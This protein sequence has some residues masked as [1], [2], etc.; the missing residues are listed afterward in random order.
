L[1]SEA[2]DP[3]DFNR[4]LTFLKRLGFVREADLLGHR[5][6]QRV[7]PIF[8]TSHNRMVTRYCAWVTSEE[9]SEALAHIFTR[10]SA[11][12][13]RQLGE[14]KNGRSDAYL[15][16][17]ANWITERYRVVPRIESGRLCFQLGAGLPEERRILLEVIDSKDEDP[18][19]A[20][21]F[22]M[23]DFKKPDG[24][25]VP[26]F[27]IQL[28]ARAIDADRLENVLGAHEF[29]ETAWRTLDYIEPDADRRVR[30][31]VT[32]MHAQKKPVQGPLPGRYSPGMDHPAPPSAGPASAPAG[33]VL[34]PGDT[35]GRAG[36]AKV[37]TPRRSPAREIKL[38]ATRPLAPLALRADANPVTSDVT[39]R[40]NLAGASQASKLREAYFP[41]FER[42]GLDYVASVL[43]LSI[44][45]LA[46][47][48]S[49]RTIPLT[50]YFAA[51]DALRLLGNTKSPLE[52][53]KELRAQIQQAY[54]ECNKAITDV[55]EWRF[56][57]RLD[58]M[59]KSR[60]SFRDTDIR[61]LERI[62]SPP[63]GRRQSRARRAA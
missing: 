62:F 21:Y 5:F 1:S 48:R 59:R 2:D 9:T 46:P 37:A 34:H 54:R 53:S 13:A 40:N 51:Q 26:V 20:H 61:A 44:M 15:N 25:T 39:G 42:C 18:G 4:Y 27:L 16:A 11:E 22:R 19:D 63:S 14:L 35:N 7:A 6:F 50:L 10:Y 28:Q 24:R 23:P 41:I 29:P 60:G 8:R 52:R 45:Q 33:S 58:A 57:K 56:K 49:R 36:P 30:Q 3:E 17:V 32:S 43:G 47:L 38:P 12:R 55:L 31:N